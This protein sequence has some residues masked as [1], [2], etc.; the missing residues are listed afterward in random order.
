M[1][2]NLINIL[3]LIDKCLTIKNKSVSKVI[4]AFLTMHLIRLAL[5]LTMVMLILFMLALG[6]I[7]ISA[8]SY[9][10]GNLI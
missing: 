5:A 3:T 8:H 2:I 7:S 4:L 1:G 10:K 6:Y 9:H